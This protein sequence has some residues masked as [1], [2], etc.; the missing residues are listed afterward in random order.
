[1]DGTQLESGHDP[2][3]PQQMADAEQYQGEY[4][5]VTAE[6]EQYAAEQQNNAAQW[7]TYQDDQGADYYYNTTTGET[8]YDH[9]Y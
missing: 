5:A 8:T 2:T 1:M 3:Y 6:Y 9:P 4:D 7:E